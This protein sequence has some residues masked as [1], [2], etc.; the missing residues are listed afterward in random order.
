MADQN[1][2][3]ALSSLVS[4]EKLPIDFNFTID[5][6][7]HIF[8]QNLQFQKSKYGEK[9]SYYLEI[10]T[11]NLSLNIKNSD[12]ELVLNPNSSN[13]EESIIP[14]EFFYQW[15]VIKYITDFNISN[16][17]FE[18]KAYFNLISDFLRIDSNSIFSE[19]IDKFIEIE[20][21]QNKI[22]EFI[23][24]YN[25]FS[26]AQVI[27][28]PTTDFE[29]LV[30]QLTV[31]NID[32]LQ[33]IFSFFIE[34]T[35]WDIFFN[36]QKLF[37][38]WLGIFSLDN[39]KKLIIPYFRFSTESLSLGLTFPRTWLKP[40]DENGNVIEG[41]T[42]SMLIYNVGSL[43]YDSQQGF[44]FI[45]T[46][47]FTLTPSQIGDTGLTIAVSGVKLDLSRTSNIP[48]AIADG[49]PDDFIGVYITDGTVG[50]PTFWNQNDGDSTGQ[51]KVRNLLVGTGGI[52]GTIGLEAKNAGDPAPLIKANFGGGF[53]VSL[54]AFDI[55]FQQNAIIGSN[56]HGTMK[57]PG[58]KDTTGADAEINIDVW[59][60]TNGEF[61][62]TASEDQGITAL[63]IPN[64]F[65]FNINS[66]SI[67]R[68]GGRFFVAI[69]GAIDFMD[70]GG[71]IGKLLPDKIDIQKLIIWQDGQ[72]EFEGGTLVLPSA[73]T[74][75]IGPVELSITAIGFGSHEQQHE[76]QLRQYKFFEFS[77]GISVN[78]G[79]V[80]ARG[81]GIKFYYT[82]DNDPGAGRNP[83]R[84]LRIQGIG[85]DIII[86][87]SADPANATLLLSGYL[88]MKDPKP[89]NEEAGT[90][91]AGGVT[92][93]LPKLKMGGS[94]AMRL[95]PKVPA[96]IV[97]VELQISTPIL[98][99]ST[100]LGIYGFRGLVGQRY[101]ATKSAAGV[102][103]DGEWWR[104]Y[105]AKIAPDYKEGIQVSK[106]DQTKGFSFGA[107]VSF[108][109][110]MDGGRIFSAKLFFLLSLP[111]VFL[112]QG[113][114][115][116]LKERIGLDTTSDPPFFALLAISKTSIEAAFGI[117]YMIPDDE[118]PGS[119]ARI[120]ALIEM[121]FFFGNSSAWYLNIGKD[122]PES[123]RV[124]ARILELFDAYFYFMLSSSGIRAGAGAKFEFNKKFGPLRAELG[125]YLDVAGKI[126]FKPKQYGASIQL[127]GKVG[128]YIFKFGFAISVDAGLAGE[129]PKPFI[130]TGKL[131][132]CI[133]ILK[134]DFCAK[135]EFTWVKNKTLDTGQIALMTRNVGAKALNIITEESF[136]LHTSATSL[137][138]LSPAAIDNYTV[139]MDSYID[140]E[141]LKGVLPSA[142][143]RQNFGGNT[144][145]AKYVDYVSPQKSK[146]SRVRHEYYLNEVNIYTWNGSAW[147]PYDIYTAATPLEDA[148]F[149]TSDLTNLKKGYWQYQQAGLHNK[150]R[151][152]AQSP[153]SFVSQGTGDLI[154]EELGI[155]S[156][157][158][159]CPPAPI[160]KTCIDFN[161]YGRKEHPGDVHATVP[162]GQ[163]I[164]S[165][166]LL[167]RIN[168]QPA[169]IAFYPNGGFLNALTIQSGDELEVLFP[170]AVSMI[171]LRLK[172]VA[173]NV[174]IHYYQRTELPTLT[175]GDLPQF[176]YTLIETKDVASFSLV[177]P[178]IYENTAVPVDKIVIEACSCKP[179]LNAMD[180]TPTSLVCD[181]NITPQG[182]DLQAFL[183]LIAKGKFDFPVS[184]YPIHHVDFEGIFQGTSLYP[185]ITNESTLLTL[186]LQAATDYSVTLSISDNFGFSCS[187][188]LT[189]G[190]PVAWGQLDSLSGLRPY[191]PEIG[192]NYRFEAEAHFSDLSTVTVTGESCYP[193]IECTES[194]LL[195]LY[196]LCY[197][198]FD[199]AQYN[200][201][202]PDQTAVQ[203]EVNSITEG[204]N[205]SI[206]PVWRP[207]AYYA[208]EVKTEDRLY[209]D[210]GSSLITS[211]ANNYIFGFKTKGPIG[212]FHQGNPTYQHLLAKDREA[213][214]KLASLQ[215]YVD[216]E[217]SYPNA[218][219]A[220]IHAKPLFYV[221]PELLLFYLKNY[222]YEFYRNW[223]EYQ[224][225][226][227][228]QIELV[229][230]IADPAPDITLP[231]AEPIAVTW[232]ADDLPGFVQD[233]V[234]L[235]NM[236][237][238]G[239]PC[240]NT[241]PISPMGVHSV[242]SID[243]LEPLKLY[244]ASFKARYK[245][246]SQSEYTEEEVH[247]Y[248]FQTSRYES[249]EEQ[250][251]SYVLER[252][253]EDP[254]IITKTA[255]FE[256][257]VLIDS[258]QLTT[259]QAI[260]NNTLDVNSPLRQEYAYDYDKLISGIFKLGALHP[261]VTTEFNLIKDE[262]TGLL[263]GVL[264]RNPE[265]FN[266]PKIPD[267]VI[268]DT[269]QAELGSN[270]LDK[271]VFSK[272]RRNVFITN[273]NMDVTTGIYDFQFEYLQWSGAQYDIKE[274][275]SFLL[276]LI[277]E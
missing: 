221:E 66:L 215:Y 6:F 175:P 207:N 120:N 177:N 113:Q 104:Y 232:Q 191:Q 265:P 275:V 246:A 172:T 173:P 194:C 42:K 234:I 239:N 253:E 85:I 254:L 263:L 168:G 127:G 40:L 117:D 262:T 245:T 119:I 141:F 77:G 97:D 83:H 250:V 108:A 201:T 248:V 75:K 36:I 198:K 155:T 132:V 212:F 37:S 43:I 227:E 102:P 74:L 136:N 159:F 231:P 188:T 101:V 133:V 26:E 241:S 27:L 264:I 72:I 183:N 165:N 273:G 90:E 107:G 210:A 266:D 60:G 94:A 144:Q 160:L 251:N 272:D 80:D 106:F 123:R 11:N 157:T 230:T 82:V 112:L 204:F 9:A 238:N 274:T 124:N 166:D 138:G 140:M 182:K 35:E 244:T 48:E 148:P 70:Q 10:I 51:L 114:G 208:V 189:S 12:F 187:I 33:L 2:Y 206:Q 111:E 63:R 170:D 28:N 147:V 258:T 211:Y 31:A 79:G 178:V 93:S 203:N 122:L 176:D 15:E 134:K 209:K 116:M 20:P 214:F 71:F 64:I 78:P 34:N 128:L 196:Q 237:E 174:K 257:P 32:I 223:D 169:T 271:K 268:K 84:Y 226:E 5:F 164:S 103:E 242:V 4:F 3:P 151:I 21:G 163:V 156:E 61:S 47:S 59:I 190:T 149:V 205:Q 146:S 86:P 145:G 213:E 200:A 199:D 44:D 247:R 192:V 243:R 181:T 193:I 81:D 222:V 277:T 50:F 19:A 73:L 30:D 256:V 56:I 129:A 55:T 142:G 100:G 220:L 67:G 14:I 121:G 179:L 89:G 41:E 110:A 228:V 16:F 76:G 235:D 195:R 233:A 25:N 240:V 105:K 126:A 180:A 24:R 162:S 53:S 270:V 259:A 139:P 161:A 91:Y 150:L 167:V 217:K 236:I 109:T 29:N 22:E 98:L 202:L 130:V 249:F 224:N 52:S 69:S 49:R 54:D 135:F 185:A 225:N 260:V 276:Q 186:S 197:L 154:V 261:A 58:F 62:V 252:D 137:S 115:Q 158:I 68:K 269:V 92:F 153:L 45:G 171:S 99:G 39:L 13:N 131:K 1:Y 23:S 38:T 7:D 143:V 17:S 267:A 57:I 46:N 88:S 65:D 18:N 125:A 87:G 219:G 255:R 229:T 118:R 218:D 216:Y 95:N 184:M 96:F 152:M 8:Y